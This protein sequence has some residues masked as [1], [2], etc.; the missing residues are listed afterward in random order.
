MI[1]SNTLT[2]TKVRILKLHFNKMDK[3]QH[4]IVIEKNQHQNFWK[5]IRQFYMIN[6]WARM[7][8]PRPDLHLQ[9]SNI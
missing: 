8:C 1:I 6:E 9:L 2:D 3:E 7:Q 5:K 4:L